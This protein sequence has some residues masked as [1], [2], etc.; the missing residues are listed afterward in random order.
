MRAG[1]CRL[2]ESSINTH[3]T[4]EGLHQTHSEGF[5]ELSQ[6]HHDSVLE[7]GGWSGAFECE[8]AIRSLY[9]VTLSDNELSLR[10]SSIHIAM[11]ATTGGWWHR[12]EDEGRDFSPKKTSQ[13]EALNL[14]FKQTADDSSDF[15]R[16]PKGS[17]VSSQLVEPVWCLK[18]QWILE[19]LENTSFIVVQA[20]Y[21]NV[22]SLLRNLPLD[23]DLRANLSIWVNLYK[24]S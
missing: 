14:L 20:L 7:A 6:T 1:L 3:A 15:W 16:T 11:I 9:E 5:S 8:R 10:R 19:R 13:S 22:Y 2:I 18:N 17:N 24:N 21:R 12:W 4:L 23:G